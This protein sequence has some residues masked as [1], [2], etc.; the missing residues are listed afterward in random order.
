GRAMLQERAD[1]EAIG[2]FAENLRHL[3]LQPPLGGKRVLAVDPGF[4]TGCKVVVLD[5]QGGLV[6]ET[7]I[8][9]HPPQARVAEAR[10]A[11]AALA[12]RHRIEAV[13][14]G[15]GTAGRETHEL[16]RTMKREKLLAETCAVVL[17]NESGASVYS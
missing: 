10:Q 6:E 17:V 8:H 7:V 13:A 2:V 16:V 4:R 5:E 1:A 11:L 14:V 9:P 3:L 12:A 15:N